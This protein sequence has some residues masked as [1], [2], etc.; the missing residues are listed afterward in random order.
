MFKRNTRLAA[1]LAVLL[2]AS[3]A[4]AQYP[5]KLIK[6]VSPA[7]PGGSTDIVARMVQPGLQDDLKQTVI[8]EARGGAGGY[9]GSEY[10][11]RQPADGYSLLIG[12][13]FVAI[14]AALQKNPS[15]SPRRDL[16]PVAILASVPNLLVAGPRLK[17]NSVAELIAEAR[18]RPGALNIGSNGVG[19][20]LHLSGE[21]FKLQA[22]VAFT[23]IAY[24]GWA[25]CVAALTTGEI[26][27]MFDN[28][29]TALPNIAA[30]KTRAL[31]TA[32]PTRHRALPDVPTLAETGVND[33]DVIS[34]FGVMVRSGTPQPVI[35]TLGRAFKSIAQRPEFHRLVA[36]Q[37]LDVTYYGPEQA[38]T[39]WNG[40]IDKWERV[41][42][43]AGIVAQ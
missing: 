15:Y 37:S 18:A 40:E 35:D 1:A 30:G 19:T 22:N 29:S 3:P 14:T 16:V 27:L 6:I 9:L 21:L 7:P 31:A 28:L 34:W 10:V 2:C 5:N 39:F 43:A 13:A 23:H 38:A 25:D 24:R 33:A 42:K 17:A 4:L 41:I 20:T 8:V 11:T 12:G 36:E 32:A 26:D